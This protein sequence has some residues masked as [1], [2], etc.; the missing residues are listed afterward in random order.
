[1]PK[2]VAL[3]PNLRDER[4]H[5]YAY[6]LK[7]AEAAER[8]GW[9]YVVASNAEAVASYWPSN[10]KKVFKTPE[11]KL[12]PKFIRRLIRNHITRKSITKTMREAIVDDSPIILKI[13]DP[14]PRLL[15]VLLCSLLF[16]SR[17]PI[18]LWL[19]WYGPPILS[20]KK[21]KMLHFY[22]NLI[23]RMMLPP[24]KLL[25][26]TQTEA[27]AL[28]WERTLDHPVSVM[29]FPSFPI[30]QV[31]VLNRQDDRILCWFAGPPYP[32]KKKEHI[33][34]LLDSPHPAAKQLTIMYSTEARLTIGKGLANGRPLPAVL[35]HD[36][37]LCLLA[38]ADLM[39]LPYDPGHGRDVATSGIFIETILA[40]NTPVVSDGTWMAS[41]L[42]KFGLNE[43]IVDWTSDSLPATLVALKEDATI[44]SRLEPMRQHYR[45]Y[46]STDNFT[47]ALSEL[48]ATQY[49][50]TGSS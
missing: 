14:N 25:V 13:E 39:L 34:S 29:P 4:G 21:N 7:A 19:Q 31:P 9:E 32:W 22:V 24:H 8:L 40:G 27:L 15:R 41:E 1:M 44:A 42:R 16:L 2:I 20:D 23:K 30:E 6:H 38:S 33:Q 17:H 3:V 12:C 10:W 43:L 48:L 45:H 5:F 50:F 35:D 47:A 49:A 36:R 46:Y 18:S 28:L 26:T 37:Y 11:L